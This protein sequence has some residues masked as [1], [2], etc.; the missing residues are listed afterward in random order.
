MECETINE[1]ISCCFFISQPQVCVSGEQSESSPPAEGL[2]S[3]IKTGNDTS[4]SGVC[5]PAYLSKDFLDLF[6]W[7]LDLV[8]SGC[9]D[10]VLERTRE[11]DL[12]LSNSVADLVLI[13]LLP[14]RHRSRPA[15][16]EGS[17]YLRCPPRRIIPQTS[18]K[19]TVRINS[20]S[21]VAAWPHIFP[22]CSVA[23]SG[24][25]QEEGVKSPERR[26]SSL[27]ST[28]TPPKP[29]L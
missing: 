23:V 17:Q 11:M 10:D 12:C 4:I 15:D 24:R 26:D 18:N 14:A 20:C 8:C 5:V 2:L 21:R 13:A 19:Q 22:H 3:E 28:P 25:G 6:W 1:W 27:L 16:D 29:R 7:L 9:L